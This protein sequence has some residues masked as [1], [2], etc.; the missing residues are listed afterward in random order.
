MRLMRPCWS[1]SQ[2]RRWRPFG[3]FR[4]PPT[5]V[6]DDDGAYGNVGWVTLLKDGKKL[7]TSRVRQSAGS[8]QQ[9]ERQWIRR[10]ANDKAAK[11]GVNSKGGV[12]KASHT[13]GLELSCD[14]T[15]IG[16]AFGGVEFA[17]CF[18]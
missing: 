8:R 12:V 7:V 9:H 6:T 14:P 11:G 4:A 13:V 16:F 15:G 5:H 2:R 1:R 17:F 10:L 18:C 3:W